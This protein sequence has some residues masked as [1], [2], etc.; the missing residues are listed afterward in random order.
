MARPQ[1]QYVC[2]Q[3][4]AVHAKWSGRC[5]ACGAWNSLIEETRPEKMP[6]GLGGGA[7]KGHA[8]DFVSLQLASATNVR[9]ILAALD[10]PGVPEVV[11]ID[12]I[13]TLYVDTLDS[14]PGTVSQVRAS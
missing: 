7:A 5:D 11:V 3:C 9:D 13:Q 10:Q 2:Q 1:N 14:A 8:V 12:S 4:G 6:K